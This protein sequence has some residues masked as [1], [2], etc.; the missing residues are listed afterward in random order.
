MQQITA[1]STPAPVPPPKRSLWSGL[2]LGWLA[3]GTAMTAALAAAVIFAVTPGTTQPG[4]SPDQSSGDLSSGQQI[5]LAAATVAQARPGNTGKYWHVKQQYEMDGS[6]D[7]L[8]NW[9]AHN[10]SVYGLSPER[11][12]V[13]LLH[14]GGLS[15]AGS[16]LTLEQLQQ[17][18]TDPAALKTWVTDSFTH[19]QTL[20][21]MPGGQTP[22]VGVMDIPAEVLPGHVASALGDLLYLPAPPAVRAAALRALATMPNV[23]NLG[24][25]DGGRALKISFPPPPADKFPG[26]KLPAGADHVI[27]IIDTKTSMLLSTTNYQGTIRIVTAEWTDKMPKIV[28]IPPKSNKK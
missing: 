14:T 15:V 21:P 11:D 5:L 19:P 26:G 13:W 23:T 3:G 12:S 27:L 16:Q 6:T 10:G 28:P 20:E 2:R 18:P 17:L 4:P 1:T 7:T 22:P 8:E 24:A 9:T 25:K